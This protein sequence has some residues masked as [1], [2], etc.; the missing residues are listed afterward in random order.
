MK[1]QE[2]IKLKATRQKVTEMNKPT[3]AYVDKQNPHQHQNITATYLQDM[4]TRQV[5]THSFL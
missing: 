2:I 3:T 4:C 1:H 5:M